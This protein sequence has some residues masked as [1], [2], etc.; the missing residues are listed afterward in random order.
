[1]LREGGARSFFWKKSLFGKSQEKMICLV[2][3]GKQVI[4][5]GGKTHSPLPPTPPPPHVSSGPPF[6]DR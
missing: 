1:M 4:S 2:M 3:E 5:G 6:T